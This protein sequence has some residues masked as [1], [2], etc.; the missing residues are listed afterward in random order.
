MRQDTTAMKA[1]SNRPRYESNPKLHQITFCT[2]CG[3]TIPARA[4]S[5]FR[6]GAK[7]AKG[8]RTLQVVFCE[9]CGQDYPA[10]GMACFHCGHS[11][12]RHPFHRGHIA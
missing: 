5:C 1:S 7:Q 10:K 2:G 12:P 6:C 9:K 4:L 3:E 8:E 11:N